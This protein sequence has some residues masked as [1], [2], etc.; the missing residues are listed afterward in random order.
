MDVLFHRRVNFIDEVKEIIDKTP[1]G[2]H[3][4]RHE[5]LRELKASRSRTTTTTGSG[6]RREPVTFARAGWHDVG[7]YRRLLDGVD[8]VLPQQLAAGPAVNSLTLRVSW[9]PEHCAPTGF[10]ASAHDDLLALCLGDCYSFF[11]S[12]RHLPGCYLVLNTRAKSVAVV[13]TLP[14]NW[15]RDDDHYSPHHPIASAGVAVLR[16]DDDGGYLLAELYR[17]STDRGFPTNKATLFTWCSPRSG[18]GDG[19][20]RA[21]AHQW[22]RKEVMLPLPV[23]DDEYD[24]FNFNA[25]TVFAVSSTS[26][27]WVDLWAGILVCNN[28]SSS[29][30]GTAAGDD[31]DDDD[32]DGLVFTFIPLPVV[33]GYRPFDS[34]EYRSVRC[35]DTETIKLVCMDGGEEVT[36]ALTTWTLKFPLSTDG[37]WRWEKD[38]DASCSSLCVAD[39]LD[40]A[41]P[42]GGGGDNKRR[43]R[44][45]IVSWPVVGRARPGVAHVFVHDLEYKSKENQ[46]AV[47]ESYEVS[48]D[49]PRRKV[50]SVFT[51]PA[52]SWSRAHMIMPL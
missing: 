40:D 20:P 44:R 24:F 39:L 16:T 49:V 1:A 45:R 33:C 14:A 37:G 52:G 47:T 43:L 17:H 26:L 23:P 50:V 48:L 10:I 36:V 8:P 42:V 34:T 38:E 41:I 5:I 21:G 46:W 18:S 3:Q 30:A 25:G 27:C 19:G 32:E 2:C 4:T 22:I 51:L 15:L 29:T 28:I 12:W 31:D 7:Y 9:P 13:P 6:W 11:H 35:M